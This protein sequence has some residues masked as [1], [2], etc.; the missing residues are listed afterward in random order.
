MRALLLA[1]LA[2]S[3]LAF[4]GCKSDCQIVC[5]RTNECIS[6]NVNIETCTNDCI[7]A[8]SNDADRTRRTANCAE[9][10]VERAC[11]EIGGCTTECLGML[12]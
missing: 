4:A 8:N 5:E 6:T 9:C 10:V 7:E 1:T 12:F 3:T 2:L 11:S